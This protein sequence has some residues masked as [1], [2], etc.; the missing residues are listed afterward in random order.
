MKS[1]EKQEKDEKF[2]A[3]SALLVASKGIELD[4]RV[5]YL[6][7]YQRYAD[8][9]FTQED[10][11]LAEKTIFEEMNFNIQFSTFV[12]FVNF[13]LTCGVVF[14][15]DGCSNLYV[16]T[17]EDEI[18]ARARMLVRR[19]DFIQH[20]PEKLALSLV[21]EYRMKNRLEGWN[22]ELIALTGFTSD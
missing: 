7:R 13:Y 21:K 20:E 2:W 18:L 8:K 3:A 19:G 4:K 11:E 10:Y 6:N 22:D 14:K 17:I 9:S 16:R 1:C 12:T 5:P 15:S